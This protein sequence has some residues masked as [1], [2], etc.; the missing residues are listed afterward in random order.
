[1]I[2]RLARAT[3]TVPR[4]KPGVLQSPFR[5]GNFDAWFLDCTAA[6]AGVVAL[7]PGNLDLLNVVDLMWSDFG[8]YHNLLQPRKR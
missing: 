6:A 5:L 1:M 2:S 7:R 4:R 8:P 3:T